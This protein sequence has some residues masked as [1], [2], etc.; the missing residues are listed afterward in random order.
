MAIK[1][2]PI[3]TV[4]RVVA[5]VIAAA[6]LIII[7]VVSFVNSINLDD[8]ARLGSSDVN[9]G[10]T[11][12][13]ETNAET[14]SDEDTT[15]ADNCKVMY[16][17]LKS[18]K[19]KGIP[20]ALGTPVK[21]DNVEDAVAELAE[22]RNCGE[23][24]RVDTETIA[25]HYA[26]FSNAL[27]PSG[28]TV[29]LT[30]RFVSFNDIDAFRAKLNKDVKLRVA[31]VEELETLEND[32]SKASIENVPAGAMSV[33]VKP[34]SNGTITTHIGTSS[35]KG[36]ALVFTHSSGA[37][38][39]YRLECGFQI[40]QEKVPSGIETC[41]Y[42][43]CNPKPKPE[44][45]PGSTKS[46]CLTDKSGHAS[47][48]KY[49]AGKPKVTADKKPEPDTKVDTTHKGGGGTTDSADKDK[50]SESGGKAPGT[51][52]KDPDPDRTPPPNEGGDNGEG[53]T[54]GF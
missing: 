43:N 32:E 21:A 6:I 4:G 45:P 37:V 47:D 41:K 19:E 14:V 26:G 48:Y 20:Y 46:K 2:V 35:R 12:D 40:L 52:G 9:G 7:V 24:N 23:D 17:T 29:Q 1:A 22:R 8:V 13:T 36:T 50:G 16:Y 44:C 3:Q 28:K 10:N 51:G 53:D 54:G 33:F 49:P 25:T 18:G 31:V 30:T 5:G 27:L 38:V 34:H 39:K 15:E 42:N 11:S